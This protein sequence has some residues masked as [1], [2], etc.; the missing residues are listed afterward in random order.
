MTASGPASRSPHPPG[1][2]CRI[3]DRVAERAPHRRHAAATPLRLPLGLA[4]ASG[5][6][7]FVLMSA[8]P[9]AVVAGPPS[10]LVWALSAGIGMLMTVPFAQLAARFPDQSG[11]V[12]VLAASALRSRSRFLALLG[13]WGYWFG[14]SPAMAVGAALLG[15][16]GRDG[17]WPHGSPWTA[18][19]LASA[20]LAASALVNHLGAR[21]CAWLQL[22]MVI[23]VI[24]PVALLVLAPLLGGHF[25]AAR[26]TP[27]TVPGG[28][29]SRQGLA[30]LGGAFFLAGW[31]AYGAE[32]T[33][34]YGP[35]YRGGTRDAIRSLLVM[36]VVVMLVYALVPLALIGALGLEGVTGDPAEVL[37]R[38]AD[39]ATPW[40]GA[41]VFALLAVTLVLGI[42]MIAVSSSRALCQMARNGDAWAFLGRRNRH[43]APRNALVFDV[44]VNSGLV[45]L[46]LAVNHGDVGAIPVTLLTAASVGYLVSL[47]LALVAAGVVWRS[48]PPADHAFRAP[49]GFIR[50][51]ITL[52]AF[53]GLLLLGA[54]P[55]WGWENLGLGAAVLVGVPLLA[56]RRA[57]PAGAGGT[58]GAWGG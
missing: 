41:P 49:R 52:A 46:G 47:I 30:A 4:L 29:L 5:V 15:G 6:P 11:G 45:A 58:G 8:G 54:G 13:Q 16:Y 12:A 24:A 32:V 27:F 22:L 40:S 51:G 9:V 14:W 28:W 42:N 55:T 2:R 43:G 17:L 18:W 23:G 19:V 31:S 20:V 21:P 35:E 57:R 44:A 53:N 10:V 25:D 50:L 7:A 36:G 1:L 34:T 38:F 39:S 37:V 48:S 56:S 26:L 33:L 3:C